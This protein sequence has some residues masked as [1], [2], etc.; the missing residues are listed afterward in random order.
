V[1]LAPAPRG[2]RSSLATDLNRLAAH[3][4]A[5]RAGLIVV[6]LV[7]ILAAVCGGRAIRS[8][9]NRRARRPIR[10]ARR[11]P[12]LTAFNRFAGRRRAPPRHADETAREYVDRVAEPGRLEAA[13]LTLEQECYGADEPDRA[14]VA[15]AVA[16]F[17]AERLT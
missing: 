2:S 9:A 6:V 8:R 16:A 11:R 15:E 5:G 3:L 7:L 14:E 10:R 17:G 4:P 1:R 12:V 13:L